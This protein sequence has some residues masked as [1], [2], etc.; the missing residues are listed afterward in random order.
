MILYD[1]IVT[2]LQNFKSMYSGEHV[3]DNYAVLRNVMSF[4]APS[5]KRMRIDLTKRLGNYH[6][7][8]NQ[9]YQEYELGLRHLS[10]ELCAVG[11]VMT[12]EELTLRL[13]AGMTSDKRYGK[14]CR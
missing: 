12:D 8:T 10:N 6:K 5:S 7:Q 9:G 13:I 4:G 2:S 14:E 3:G 1:L 11:T